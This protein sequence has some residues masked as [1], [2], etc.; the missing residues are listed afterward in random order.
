MGRKTPIDS[1]A[2]VFTSAPE[3]IE[4]PIAPS[5]SP[6]A[7]QSHSE[8]LVA[9][10]QLDQKEAEEFKNM[11]KAPQLEQV[12]IDKLISQ[13]QNS[14]YSFLLRRQAAVTL[15]RHLD[16]SQWRDLIGKMDTRLKEIV[17]SNPQDLLEGYI[18]AAAH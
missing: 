2:H 1:F 11:A 3:V 18:R 9:Q 4:T 16:D 12:Q 6:T 10:L 15:H 7:G 5:E 8:D 17:S 14:K 13:V